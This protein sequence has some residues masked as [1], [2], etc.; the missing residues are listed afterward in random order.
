MRGNWA[1][2]GDGAVHTSLAEQVLQIL[3]ANSVGK[4]ELSASITNA[5]LM[6]LE[7][8]FRIQTLLTKI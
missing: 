5:V 4:L 6:L 1:Y 3:P 7:G 2:K 8:W